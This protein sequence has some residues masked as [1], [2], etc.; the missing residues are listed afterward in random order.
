MKVYVTVPVPWAHYEWL[1][2]LDVDFQLYQE[3]TVT[4]G[5]FPLERT[6]WYF[7]LPDRVATLYKLKYSERT[8]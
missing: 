3:V 7:D 6:R 5:D 4:K 8:L 2:A 1:E